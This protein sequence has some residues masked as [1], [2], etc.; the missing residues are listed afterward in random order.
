MLRPVE[1]ILHTPPAHP[2]ASTCHSVI[3]RYVF[4]PRVKDV[5]TK[6]GFS[7][8]RDRGGARA[9]PVRVRAGNVTLAPRRVL[10]VESEEG[11]SFRVLG[12]QKGKVQHGIWI[13]E[14]R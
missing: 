14:P 11:K 8:A 9:D 12:A 2:A 3:K 10:R 13:P 5:G 6:E 1:C 7:R 4:F